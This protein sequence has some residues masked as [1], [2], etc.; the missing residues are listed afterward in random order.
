MDKEHISQEALLEAAMIEEQLMQK[1]RDHL[2]KWL[3]VLLVA[4]LLMVPLLYKV[5]DSLLV[6]GIVMLSVV[7]ATA[8][9]SYIVGLV[10][11]IKRGE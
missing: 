9:L 3:A 8:V 1:E 7:G 6:F 11:R 4:A 10:I 5:S 2:L